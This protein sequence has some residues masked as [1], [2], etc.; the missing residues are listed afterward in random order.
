MMSTSASPTSSPSSGGPGLSPSL[1]SPLAPPSLPHR[2]YSSVGATSRAP[3]RPTTS[4]SMSDPSRGLLDCHADV[5]ASVFLDSEESSIGDSEEDNLDFSGL[6]DPEAVRRFFGAC[7]YLLNAL[8]PD[9]GGW[10]PPRECFMMQ[11]GTKGVDEGGEHH[12]PPVARDENPPVM[13]PGGER[14]TPLVERCSLHRGLALPPIVTPGAR[15]GARVQAAA[16]AVP[17]GGTRARNRTARRNPAKGSRCAP[18]HV[19]R[20]WRRSATGLR[21]GKPKCRDSSNASPA[22]PEP[23]TPEGR[24]A[25]TERRALLERTFV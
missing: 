4:M 3:A 11:V 10:D 21:S 5:A 1:V 23:S 19:R 25:H 20:R 6:R 16:A 14:T 24:Q 13:P 15:K 22:M 7:D 17:P 12:H 18:P 8:D 2:T 9:D